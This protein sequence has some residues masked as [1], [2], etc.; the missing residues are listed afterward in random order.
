VHDAI[1][2]EPHG[3]RVEDVQ[4]INAYD[5]HTMTI[6]R[7]YKT[8][9]NPSVALEYHEGSAMFGFGVAYETAASPK[10]NVSVLGVD[11]DKILVGLGGGYDA[12]GWQ[13]GGAFG[14]VSVADVDLPRTEARMEQLQPLR[15]R[16]ASVIVNAGTYQTSYFLGGLRAARRF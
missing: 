15:D 13:L 11:N 10:G 14:I 3:M 6:A 8:T 12:D 16:P 9:F 7:N 2:I 4:G 1:T 5:V